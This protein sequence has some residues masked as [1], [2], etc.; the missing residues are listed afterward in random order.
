MALN[1]DLMTAADHSAVL[2][3]V[4]KFDSC[5][6]MTVDEY[7]DYINSGANQELLKL[8]KGKTIED[9]TRFILKKNLDWSGQEAI[10]QKQFKLDPVTKQPIL[11]PAFVMHEVQRSLADI[12]Q[13]DDAAFKFK[14]KQD[15]PGMA[16]RKIVEALHNAGILMELFQ[17]RQSATGGMKTELTNKKK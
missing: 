3:V 12:K 15:Q 7:S 16:S 14:Y 10:M 8:K 2:E 11:N 13:P 6:D 4:T 5:I 9:C 1:F 17:A